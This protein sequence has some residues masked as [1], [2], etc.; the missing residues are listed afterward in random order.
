MLQL[1]KD[2][3]VP[4]DQAPGGGAP[5]W[6]SVAV[7]KGRLKAAIIST[8]VF[9]VLAAAAVVLLALVTH[10]LWGNYPQVPATVADRV[11][12]HSG[13]STSCR[14]SLQFMLDG[15]PRAATVT[16]PDP[17][18][19]LPHPGA[20]VTLAY[21]PKDLSGVLIAGHDSGIRAAAAMIVFD[22]ALVLLPSLAIMLEIV[23]SYRHARK[24]AG[25][26]P[27]REIT[28]VVEDINADTEP[29]SL[30][31]QIPDAHGNGSDCLVRY[32]ARDLPGFAPK[33][34]STVTLW[35]V[36]D[37][38]GH[39]IITAPG[40]SGVSDATISTP[41]SFELRTLGL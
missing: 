2:L 30:L 3:Q 18:S 29:T 1:T 11:Q 5:V 35:L 15:M 19:Y 6:H 4:S 32:R 24:A 17:C 23:H 10:P 37:G 28:A 14:V 9:I 20:Q 12:I 38:E 16:D 26:K 21:D 41:N 34:G 39:A 33:T 40:C 7:R 27:W 31:L 36:A 25:K 22:G 13:K 8:A